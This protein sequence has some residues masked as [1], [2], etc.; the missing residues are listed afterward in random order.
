MGFEAENLS[1]SYFIL[2]F[3]FEYSFR[4]VFGAKIAA[5]TG[6]VLL[7]AAKYSS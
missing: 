6:V 5:L 7:K 1:N 2:L 4:A 3:N